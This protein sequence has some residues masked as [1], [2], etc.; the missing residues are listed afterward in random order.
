MSDGLSDDCKG[1]IEQILHGETN[2]MRPLSPE[3]EVSFRIQAEHDCDLIWTWR[4]TQPS[5]LKELRMR[6]IPI[7]WGIIE[8]YSFRIIT[9]SEIWSMAFEAGAYFALNHQ[10]ATDGKKESS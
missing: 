8:L 6:S 9:H 3:E 1:I 10:P 2:L 7:M 4:D 5:F